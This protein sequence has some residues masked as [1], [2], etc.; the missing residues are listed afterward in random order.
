[1]NNAH[2]CDRNLSPMWKRDSIP[3]S[4]ASGV[5]GGG[6]WRKAFVHSRYMSS[7]GIRGMIWPGKNRSRIVIMSITLDTNNTVLEGKML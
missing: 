7:L 5:Y 2:D 3:C 1:M 6:E 4:S